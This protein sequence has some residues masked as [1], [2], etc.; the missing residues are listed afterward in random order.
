MIDIEFGCHLP[1]RAHA[2][3]CGTKFGILPHQPLAL[4]LHE[5]GGSTADPADLSFVGTG[6]GGCFCRVYRILGSGGLLFRRGFCRIDV[7]KAGTQIPRA[8][9][10]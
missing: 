1:V 3:E 9:T 7:G 2:I 6:I 4:L 10:L 8:F 5:N